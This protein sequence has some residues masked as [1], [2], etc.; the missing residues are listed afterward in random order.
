MQVC[1]PRVRIRLPIATTS[2]APAG[3]RSRDL[4][5]QERCGIAEESSTKSPRHFLAETIHSRLSQSPT[6]GFAARRLAGFATCQLR[7]PE[8]NRGAYRHLGSYA[9]LYFGHREPSASPHVPY[10]SVTPK[11][12]P[13][14]HCDHGVSRS[15]HMEQV[16]IGRWIF[17]LGSAWS[18]MC[19]GG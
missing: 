8:I 3:N 17:C 18:A 15:A 9:Q 10:Q 13:V 12:T 19:M 16:L 5:Q 4:P 1:R 7:A 14:T 6:P 2:A 11:F